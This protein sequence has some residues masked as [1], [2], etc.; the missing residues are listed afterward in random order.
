MIPGSTAGLQF[1]LHVFLRN[2]FSSAILGSR[3]ASPDD[4]SAG[5]CFMNHSERS[6]STKLKALVKEETSQR[7]PFLGRPLFEIASDR[8]REL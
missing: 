8:A 6:N 3:T 2:S 5:C 7:L 1:A 4:N